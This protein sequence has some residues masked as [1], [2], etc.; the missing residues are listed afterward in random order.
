MKAAQ[1]LKI[2][3]FEVIEVRLPEDLLDLNGELK[4]QGIILPGGESTTQLKLLKRY[5]LFEPL[6][7]AIKGAQPFKKPL[8]V[9]GTCAGAILLAKEVKGNPQNQSD[10]IASLAV[11][12]I[13][14]DR[15]A[16]GTQIDS[17]SEK[18]DIDLP[19][20]GM[21]NRSHRKIEAVF[22]R[23]PKLSAICGGSIVPPL[24][25]LATRDDEPIAILQGSMLAT[26]FHPELT[27][28]T[29]LHEFFLETC[30]A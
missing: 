14:A 3:N 20:G 9:W 12:D 21:K 17:F 1:N 29:T 15:N 4:I 5:G 11:M 8:P 25:I 13:S 19:L 23:A 27:D 30:R 22:I 26:G 6:K 18:I 2:K 28:S 24:Q 16:Y 7:K 10:A